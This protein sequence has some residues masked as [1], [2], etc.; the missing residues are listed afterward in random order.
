MSMSAPSRR[1]RGDEGVTLVLVA[2][3]LVVLMVFAAFAVDIGGVY[4]ARRQDQTAAD[5]A[6]LAAAQDLQ[7]GEAT[8]VATAKQYAHD[9]LDTVLPDGADGWNSCPRPDPAGLPFQATGASCISYSDTRVRVR[10][11][12]QFYPASFGRVAG[13]AD[14]RH[15]A[16]AVAGL[17]SGGFGG[18]LPFA[19]TGASA[20]GG[21]GCLKSASNGQ[22]SALCGSSSGNFGY[23][24]FSQYGNATLGTSASCG[25]GGTNPRLEDNMAMGVDHDLSKVGTVHLTPVVDTDGC[26]TQ[27]PTPD[28]AR[29]ETG[30]M[31]DL[32]THGLFQRSGN[33]NFSDGDPARLR[34]F[35]SK[36]LNGSGPARIS[37]HNVP[38]LDNT[39]LWRFIP[40]N[41]GPGEA[42]PANIPASCKRDQF[43]NG[44][45]AY[46]D[47]LTTN[48]DLPPGIAASINNVG[49][50]RD[51]LLALFARCFAHYRGLDWDGAPVLSI[52]P[53]E[54][55][56]GCSGACSAPVFGLNSTTS[57][58]PD[59]FDI[60]YTPRFGYVPVIAD[61]PSGQNAPRTFLRFRAVYIQR[62][63]IERSGP[64]ESVWD[65]ETA[66]VPPTS[67]SFQRVSEVS[68]FV[69]PDA[70]LPGGLGGEDAPFEIGV[71]R[72]VS[73]VR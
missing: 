67:T 52:T 64:G 2:L 12:D 26:L 66:P 9:T 51:R 33:E 31:S 60:Q 58:D 40:P 55:P 50:Q 13:V 14:F 19:V 5:V 27:V 28:A 30:N 25:S 69:F 10:L 71:N 72:F 32:V 23:L 39:A 44:S 36:L 54:P 73:L 41:Y 7:K 11:P 22:A 68:V 59:L 56:A 53:P 15:S 20:G 29:T 21:F 18:V 46:Y 37:V 48:P 49:T 70:M 57:D 42:Q 61:F 1:A 34:R 24:D 3:L 65:P 17:E 6:A 63:V 38:G 35:D 4:A 45:N 62:L 47:D 8:M 16:F 43:V